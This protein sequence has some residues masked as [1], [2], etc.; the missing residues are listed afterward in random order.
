M[1]TQKANL[2]ISLKDKASK[3]IK[4]IGGAILGF[5]KKVLTS[6]LSLAALVAVIGLGIRAFA[7]FESKLVDVGN[8]FGATTEQVKELG[9]GI[10]DISREIPVGAQDLAESL[11]DVVSAGVAVGDSL[12][13]L[14]ASAKLAVA[15]VTSTKVAVDGLTSVINA[16]GFA[17]KDVGKIADKFFAAQQAGK[18]TIEEL[19]NAIGTVAP[20]AKAAGISIDELL[21][22]IA[23]LTKQGIKTDQ[24]VTQIRAALTS[25][26]KPSKEAI[27]LFAE[28]KEEN[29][30]LT[31][32]FDA[33]SLK[34]KG[35]AGF[36]KDLTE[37]TDGN[38]D[39]I[40]TLFPNV[41][42]LN[43]VLALSSKEFK[44]LDEITRKTAKAFGLVNEAAQKQQDTLGS[45]F[46]LLINNV[47]ASFFEAFGENSAIAK[48]LTS[49]LKFINTRFTQINAVIQTTLLS[50]VTELEVFS[51]VAKSLF[52]E[53][54]R[55]ENLETV[56]K[57]SLKLIDNVL[58]ASSNAFQS[59]LLKI[60]G[61]TKAN[62]DAQAA[63]TRSLEERIIAIRAAAAE[64]KLAL[65]QELDE[66]EAEQRAAKDEAT[67]AADAALAEAQFLAAEEAIAKRTEQK[68][69]EEEEKLRLEQEAAE[70]RK[71]IQNFSLDV[72]RNIGDALIDNEKSVASAIGDSIK[73]ALIGQIDAIVATEIAKALAEAPLTFGATLAAIGPIIAAGAVGRAAI[74][75]IKFHEGGVVGE[76]SGTETNF[77]RRLRVNEKR[78]IL[79]DGE[80]V[81]TR[82]TDRELMGMLSKIN[83]NLSQRGA[84]RQTIS[85]N[86]SDR[87]IAR[88]SAKFQP[89]FQKL[90]RAGSL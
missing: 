90:N 17:A 63:E 25:I 20:T 50:I 38:I 89:T 64:R 80:R 76:G 29:S 45:Q 74:G 73:A 81:L 3:G 13:F 39:K 79:E 7:K 61:Q 71:A 75:A 66:K 48:K 51:E 33:A 46:T 18:T 32:E 53:P 6:K 43:G 83:A 52:L 23:A 31:G 62:A 37:A 26:I 22:G 87:E 4:R 41:R 10:L 1:A 5:G 54:F 47:K 77:N 24:A 12:E 14:A 21:G 34:A 72:T 78:A 8:L 40:A 49:L 11:F 68:A 27:E 16:Y 35:L 44:E 36:L 59:F 15:G 70:K 86:V 84:A 58:S 55:K 65:Q 67:L 42:A 60:G 69:R 9:D 28:L 19:S 85:I 30:D 88:A 82:A 56:L 57:G 2:I